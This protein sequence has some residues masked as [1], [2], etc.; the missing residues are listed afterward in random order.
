MAIQGREEKLAGKIVKCPRTGELTTALLARFGV[1]SGW[2][3]MS[4]VLN[5][6]V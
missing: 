5:E 1:D 3:N 6:G 4:K 2:E